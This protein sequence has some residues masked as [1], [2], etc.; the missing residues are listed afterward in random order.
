M[1]K[2]LCTVLSAAVVAIT[3]FGNSVVAQG[4]TLPPTG[5]DVS[6]HV[7]SAITALGL[8][9]V[10]VAGGFFAFM[11]IRYGFRWARRLGG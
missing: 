8:I 9:V 10:T 5:V 6:G 7:T 3:A 1:R 11:L 4:I 2:R